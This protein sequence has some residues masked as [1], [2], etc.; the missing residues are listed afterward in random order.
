M[1]CSSPNA[2]AARPKTLWLLFR[3]C[4]K[5]LGFEDNRRFPKEN[6]GVPQILGVYSPGTLD[7]LMAVN[8]PLDILI[9]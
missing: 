1:S 8:I 2:A 9:Q 7:T 3:R 4:T 5:Q 6:G